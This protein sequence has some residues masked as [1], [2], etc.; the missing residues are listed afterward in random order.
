MLGKEWLLGRIK[1]IYTSREAMPVRIKGLP[2]GERLNACSLVRG[3]LQIHC[4]QVVAQMLLS[5]SAHNQRR[6]PRPS[7]EAGTD[8]SGRYEDA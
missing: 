2:A 5:P 3:K 1:A 7:Y 8:P 4:S 6:N